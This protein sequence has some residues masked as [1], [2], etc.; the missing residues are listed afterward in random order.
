[1]KLTITVLGV[2]GKTHDIQVDDRQRIS[3]TLR[4][5]GENMADFPKDVGNVCV[6]LFDS[7]RFVD[8]NHTY[9]EAGIYT[10]AQLR[11]IQEKRRRDSEEG[12]GKEGEG[13]IHCTDEEKIPNEL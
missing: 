6:R 9:K 5:L 10:G 2:N 7:G 8:M 3:T 13:R 1:M 11:I 12:E 4:V